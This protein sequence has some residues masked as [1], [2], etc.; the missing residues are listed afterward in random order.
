MYK[1]TAKDVI[2][3]IARDFES[4]F[5]TDYKVKLDFG[6]YKYQMNLLTWK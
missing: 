2:T 6:K 1:I 5:I 4:F 3:D